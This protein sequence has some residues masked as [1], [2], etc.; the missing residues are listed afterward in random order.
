MVNKIHEEVAKLVRK[1]NTRNPL[2]IAE[3][4]GI[5]LLFRDLN[6]LKGFYTISK[7]TRYIVINENLDEYMQK[8][9]C[10]HELGHD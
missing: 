9:I 8:V 6:N 2:E 3:S 5:T 1:Y 10:A 7:R 4:M